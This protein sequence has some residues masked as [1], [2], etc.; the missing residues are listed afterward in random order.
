MSCCA[1]VV[2]HFVPRRDAG[3]STAWQEAPGRRRR[4]RC[5]ASAVATC[6][7]LPG[8]TC[9]ASRS[10]SASTSSC[11]RAA[12]WLATCEACWERADAAASCDSAA[13]TPVGFLRGVPGAAFCSACTG[14][15]CFVQSRV[16]FRCSPITR[17]SSVPY[18]CANRFSRATRAS[19][20]PVRWAFFPRSS[21][22]QPDGPLLSAWPVCELQRVSLI[23]GVPRGWFRA[24]VL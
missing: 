13:R 2:R 20:P 15:I 8:A 11:D 21:R 5:T 6:R 17:R 18:W 9:A 16:S 10:R 3:L 24:A 12:R 4:S 1:W 14:A 22:L 19:F 23:A 7:Y